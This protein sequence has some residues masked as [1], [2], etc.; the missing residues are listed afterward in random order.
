MDYNINEPQKCSFDIEF[1]LMDNII[2][3]IKACIGLLENRYFN[4]INDKLRKYLEEDDYFVGQYYNVRKILRN[5]YKKRYDYITFRNKTLNIVI[6]IANRIYSLISN[7]KNE[8][9]KGLSELN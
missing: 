3:S 6:I 8:L 7:D 2:N 9:T 4:E 5:Y 1:N